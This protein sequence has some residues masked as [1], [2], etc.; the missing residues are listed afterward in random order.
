VD[1]EV[2]SPKVTLNTLE[3]IS[4]HTPSGISKPMLYPIRVEEFRSPSS[5]TVLSLGPKC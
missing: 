2:R 3:G 4:I 1:P 5:E